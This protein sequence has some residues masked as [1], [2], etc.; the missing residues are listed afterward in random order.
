MEYNDIN[1]AWANKVAT[2]QLGEIALN[3]LH[4]ILKLIQ[5][6]ASKN[7]FN[8]TVFTLEDINKKEDL[9][10]LFIYIRRFSEDK[11]TKY[12][13]MCDKC[14]YLNADDTLINRLDDL[15]IGN[16]GGNNADNWRTCPYCKVTLQYANI[17]NNVQVAEILGSTLNTLALHNKCYHKNIGISENEYSF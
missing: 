2:T 17:K 6:A 5:E 15:S 4:I 8:I 1:A 7:K 11:H 14:F 10:Y 9:Y 12:L 16:V 3:Q 13:T